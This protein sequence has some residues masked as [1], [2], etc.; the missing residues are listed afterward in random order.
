M[1][2]RILF[3][4]NLHPLPWQ[5]TRATY[6]YEEIRNLKAHANVRVL[7]PVP[8][9]TWF[10]QVVLKG[11]RSPEGFCLFPFFYVPKILTSFHPLFLLISLI[12]SVKPL[13]WL[14]KSENVIASWAYAEAVVAAFGKALFK[15]KLVI[16][17]L[18]SDV[19]A[20]MQQPLHKRQ[21]CW[22]FRKSTAVTTKS[23]ALANAVKQHVPDVNP[24]VIYNGVDFDVFTLR[25]TEPFSSPSNHFL[26][27]GSLIATK[28]VF[29]LVEG[30]EEAL[31]QNPRMTLKIAGEGASR[32]ALMKIVSAK[33][34]TKAVTFLGAIPHQSLVK[35]LH[36]S[37]ALILPSYR[38]GVPNVI[39][40]A[41][42][43]GT[44]VIATDVGGIS[45]VLIPEVG[46]ILIN[47]QCAHSVTQAL[48]TLP[49]STWNKE[50][51]RNSISK[52]T[53]DNSA[54]QIMSLFR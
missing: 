28:G 48:L 15:Y 20:L 2:K 3:F 4:T 44:P 5:P 8:W 54:K 17:C 9:F 13:I 26:F 41:L 18:G 38:E 52:Y 40:E 36:Q 12:I 23:V 32:D 27:V 30:F 50:K 24:H 11:H 34:F 22:A 46:G 25:Q 42:A 35:E 6:N 49:K 14:A 19:N 37:D 39:M 29:E 21:M 31:N 43:T 1:K 10:K 45:E 47:P 51:I 53:W 33:S 7:M 16:E